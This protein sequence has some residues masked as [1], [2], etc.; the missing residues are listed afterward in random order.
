M[1]EKKFTAKSIQAAISKVKADL[2]PDAMIISTRRILGNLRNPYGQDQFE[3]TAASHQASQ[4]H[5]TQTIPQNE[6]NTAAQK[7]DQGLTSYSFTNDA[8]SDDN[9]TMLHL[10]S[11]LV[12]IKDMLCLM[13]ESSGMPDI[14]Q[15]HPECLNWYVKIIR[16]GFPE[17]KAR[18]VIQEAVGCDEGDEIPRAEVLSQKVAK[19]LTAGIRVLDPYSRIN[20]EKIIAAYVGPTGVGKTTTIAKLAAILSLS[21]Q[22]KVG[23][24]SID[25]FRVGAV[26]QLKTYAAIMGLP[27]IP[28][29]NRE[30][31]LM[32]INKLRNKEV[33][34]IDTAGHSHLDHRRMQAL[35]EL[36]TEDL[37][38]FKHLVLS[39]G[40]NHLDI[41]EVTKCFAV[42]KP[43]TYVLTK[44]DETKHCGR[45][46]SQTQDMR[47]PLSFMTNGQR[48][49]EDILPATKRHILQYILNK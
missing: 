32:A 14:V 38:I 45:I 26:E 13:G 4:V 25:G 21:Q 34:L 43:Q 12:A 15:M 48:V 44:L 5:Q 22:K 2:G 3:V 16:S 24:I 39:A 47:L 29:F 6:N 28:A 10:R 31:L 40:M 41:H 27:C 35:E 49:P 18:Q 30:D 23:L 17:K 36:L 33:I 7:L 1:M 9:Q 19:A 46:L 20:G 37:Q 42:F 8:P 11:E